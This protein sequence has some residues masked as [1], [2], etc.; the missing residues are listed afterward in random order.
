MPRRLINSFHGGILCKERYQLKLCLTLILLMIKSISLRNWKTHLDS[1]LD[2][3]KGTNVIVGPMGSGKS[4]LMD[5][6]S[7]ALY[8]TFPSH[9]AKKVSLEETI[10]ARPMKQEKA[11]LK[12]WFDYNRKEYEVERTVKRSGTNEAYLRENGKLISGP[13]TTDVNN[14]VEEIL[15]VNYDLF[16]R[17]IYSE[18]NEI[19]FFLKLAPSKRKEKFDELLG[20]DRYEKV[21]ANAVTLTSRLKK[22][23]EDRKAFLEEQKKKFD[24]KQ[25]EDY[26]KKISEKNKEATEKIGEMGQTE[27]ELK[28]KESTVKELEELEKEEKKLR[29]E[30]IRT[31]SR[32]ESVK[33]QI[34]NSNKKIGGTDIKQIKEAFKEKEKK[35]EEF[36]QEKKSLK[37]ETEEEEKILSEAREK[38]AALKNS[39]ETNQRNSKNLDSLKGECPVCKRPLDKQHRQKLE[40]ELEEETQKIAREISMIE[41]QL[42]KASHALT[43]LRKKAEERE[44]GKEKL[45]KEIEELKKLIE[46]HAELSE[47]EKQ[48]K[49]LEGEVEKISTKISHSKFD[50]KKLLQERKEFLE[51]REKN[52]RL[53]A[54]VS[55]TKELLK[56]LEAGAQRIK[57][58][59]EQ[60]KELEKQVAL[61]GLATEKLSIFTSALKATQAE[62]RSTMIETI[63]E[64]MDEIWGKVYPYEDLQSVRIMVQEGSYEVMV[65]QRNGEWARVEGILSGGERSSAALTLRIAVSLVLTQNLGWIILDEPTHNLDANAVRGLSEMMRNHLPELIEQVFI[66]THD[67]EME[68]A[69][70]GRLYILEREKGSDGATRIIGE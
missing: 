6:I 33:E 11:E 8:G 59:Q 64:A 9:N 24:G 20:L 15:E 13:K 36:E 62:L 27:Q 69:A 57:E 68:N 21:R 51:L 50:E 18:Q 42:Q 37:K 10:M 67:K 35:L 14:K 12:L 28:K 38:K 2:F 40:K 5:S 7:F 48:R 30:H 25:L 43:A 41:E 53:R 47:K 31:K 3:A 65:K 46:L 60:I 56:E 44:E 58:A 17:A 26:E 29:E 16:S 61:N 34:E 70:S 39:L 4:S 52:S 1:R 22:I 19:D 55:S 23:V 32:L 54:E 49:L 45:S 63:N 66:I